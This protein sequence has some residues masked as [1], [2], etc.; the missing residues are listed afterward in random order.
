MA[1]ELHIERSSQEGEEE[2]IPLAEW[3]AAVSAI[4]G[5]RL[6]DGS[7]HEFV[8]PMGPNLRIKANEGD[9]EVFFPAENE[10]MFVFRWYEGTV[11]F[12]ARMALEPATP[13][14]AAAAA[15]ASRLGAKIQGDEGEIYD[16][17]TGA[18]ANDWRG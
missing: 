1:Y 10:W 15:L 6:F 2:P 12:N 5:V 7:T 13:A 8:V 9:A 17:Q 11:S 3:K 14:W 18:I 16:L 4:D